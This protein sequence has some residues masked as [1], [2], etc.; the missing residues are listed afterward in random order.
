MR[1]RKESPI[2]MTDQPSEEDL[3]D[4]ISTTLPVLLNALQALEFV[5][6]HIHPPVLADVVGAIGETATPLRQAMERFEGI[7]WPDHLTQFRMQVGKVAEEALAALDGLTKAAQDPMGIMPA[8][9]ALGHQS[10]A[11]EALYP[12]ATLFAP[13]SRFFLSEPH[14]TD[15]ALLKKLEGAHRS[16]E[17]TGVMHANNDRKERGGFSVYV[18]EYY[19]P[20]KSWPLIVALHGGS[21]HG[22]PFLWS[23]LREARTHG[24]ILIAP[25]SV[26]ETWSLAGPDQDTANLERMVG[27]ARSEWT[28]DAQHML[29]TGMSDG[30]TFCYVSGLLESSPFTHLAPFSASFHPMLLEF[31]E[32]SRIKDLPIYLTHGALDW[33]FPIDMAREAAAALKGAGADITFREIEDLSHTY[34][35]EENEKIMSWLMKGQPETE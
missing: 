6:R 26:G 11:I 25:T 12:L 14:R 20:E 3:L 8:Y 30:G 13:V 1:Q 33:M 4:A 35:R 24:A 19:D 29:L 28:I 2:T 7:A 16:S 27:F 31:V 9:R 18:P 5:A 15:E 17:T 10:K 22:R 32:E 34:G 21:G 23:W